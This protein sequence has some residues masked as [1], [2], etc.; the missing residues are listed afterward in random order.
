MTIRTLFET[1]YTSK[2]PGTE[3]GVNEIQKVYSPCFG[4]PFM[5]LPVKTYSDMLMDR[6]VEEESN[7]WLVNTGMDRSGDRYPL[8]ETRKAIKKVLDSKVVT[9]DVKW[10]NPVQPC[11]LGTID[12]KEV[13]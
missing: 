11:K 6:I 1:G 3:D 4:S 12:L 13:T 8:G 10:T 2:M 5:P 9:R 7:V